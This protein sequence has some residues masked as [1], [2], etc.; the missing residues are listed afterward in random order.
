MSDEQAQLLPTIDEDFGS[1][2]GTASQ[3]SDNDYG[4]QKLRVPGSKRGTSKRPKGT[5]HFSRQSS[6]YVI[7]STLP[8]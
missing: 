3:A 1:D 4:S 2:V 6:K 8:F 7:G 5:P